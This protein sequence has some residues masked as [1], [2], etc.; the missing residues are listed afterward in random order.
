M[1]REAFLQSYIWIMDNTRLTMESIDVMMN[2]TSI[3][4]NELQTKI[5]EWFSDG[6]AMT[7]A[8]MKYERELNES[9]STK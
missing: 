3:I 8:T 1:S 7:E 5:A 9:L 4:K 6:D 2:K